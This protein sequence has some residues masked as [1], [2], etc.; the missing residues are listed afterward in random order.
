MK[1][2]PK[3]PEPHF[4]FDQTGKKTQVL[5]DAKAYD[6]LIEFVEDLVLGKMAEN[7]LETSTKED[8]IDFEDVRNSLL[9]NA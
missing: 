4:V 1:N 2:G 7:I 9:K 5:L 8:W 3:F 6:K